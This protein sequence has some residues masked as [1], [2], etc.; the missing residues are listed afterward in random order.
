MDIKNAVAILVAEIQNTKEYKNFLNSKKTIN[1][2]K[3]LNDQLSEFTKKQETLYSSNIS[4][5]IIQQKLDEIN[6][7][8]ES[9]LK[10][11]EISN[12]FSNGEKLN[13]LVNNILNNIA[14]SIFN[15]LK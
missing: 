1:Q 11:P 15:Q 4:P 9:L 14:D 2:N 10:T 6:A 12:F 8:Y 13:N 7:N 3:Y 5:M